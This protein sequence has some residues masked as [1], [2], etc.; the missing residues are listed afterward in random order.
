MSEQFVVG[1]VFVSALF[2]SIMDTTVVNVAVPT[3]SRQF[4][5]GNSAVQWI[6]TGYLLSLALWMPA[7]GW[8]A[9][10]FGAKRVLVGA[11][12]LFTLGSALC[13]VAPSLATLVVARVIQGVGGGMLQP[14]GMAMVFRAF[15]PAQRARASQILI[16][17]TA[18][19][20]ALGPIVGGALVQH[21]SWR[22][23]FLINLPIGVVA[24]IFG[25]LFLR[26]EPHA[27]PG[28][29]DVAGFV[30][31]GSGLPLLLFAIS[32]GPSE[33]WGSATIIL[34]AALGIV[35]LTALVFVELAVRDPLLDLR[36]L[37]NRLFR[38][39]TVVGVVAF[40]GFLGTLFVLPLFL[41]EATGRS[42]M[43]SG[44]TTF[45]EALGVLALT[46][47]AG[48]LYPS[49]GPRRLMAGGLL[50]MSAVIALLSL[51][52]ASTSLW[53]I[54]LAMFGIGGGLAFVIISQQAAA[55]A[56]VSPEDT[57]RGSA[58]S[59]AVT[60]TSAAAGVALLVTVLTAK[61][62][63]NAIPVP[64]DFH[65]VFLVAAAMLLAGSALALRIRDRDA[66]GTMH[67]ASAEVA[68]PFTGG[69]DPA[70]ER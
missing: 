37:H 22:W 63:R 28:R 54:R 55:F 39:C 31:A 26:N 1:T 6:A 59:A 61:A 66:A 3:I 36:L 33:G 57:G 67:G 69:G 45:P 30:L 12:A 7:S 14:V 53:L 9:D 40:G 68:E 50:M 29:F 44:L 48:R 10:R 5:E 23:A 21:A 27:S 17:P 38:D 4:H 8:I 49:V 32:Q 56:T 15:P 35:L 41:Q 34:C 13:A 42:A 64:S 47:V 43:T 70:M 60:Q 46:Q 52:E 65:V 19:A 51:L 62:G 2:M 18:V 58:I 16:V 24:L 20:P 11:I 25:A